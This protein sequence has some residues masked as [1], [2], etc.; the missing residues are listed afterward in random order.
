MYRIA[1]KFLIVAAFC[2]VSMFAAEIDG[3][4]TATFDTP[5][6]AMATSWQ[7]K[8]D[9]AK[10]TGKSTS[11]MGG[12]DVIEGKIDGKEVSWVE[13]FNFNGNSIR[14]VYKGTINGDELKLSRTVGDFGTMEAVAKRE[15]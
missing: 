12:Q 9:G 4:W 2:A 3:K 5:M 13:V 10:L 1:R 7:L 6:G 11:D 8:A 14:F 15:K